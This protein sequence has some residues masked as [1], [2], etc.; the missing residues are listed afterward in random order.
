MVADGTISDLQLAFSREQPQKIYVQH[1][2]VEP[3]TAKK[4]YQMLEAG[5]YFYVCG[6]VLSL[7][8]LLFRIYTQSAKR[9][10]E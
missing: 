8:P 10:Q 7:S 1:K 4:L 3:H 6:F 5:A 9:E 2:M